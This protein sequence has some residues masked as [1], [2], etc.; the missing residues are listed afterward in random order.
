[1]LL[2][3]FVRILCGI[4]IG[5]EKKKKKRGRTLQNATFTGL[6]KV[7][8]LFKILLVFQDFFL[9]DTMD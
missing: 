3:Q 6:D 9:Y 5:T 2:T 8:G 7:K 1:M 4:R